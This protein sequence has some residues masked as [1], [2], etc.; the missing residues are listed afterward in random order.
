MS[1]DGVNYLRWVILCLILVYIAN[2]SS[3]I[4]KQLEKINK[5]KQD[6]R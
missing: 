6:W 3:K 4:L 5:D 1:L 2:N